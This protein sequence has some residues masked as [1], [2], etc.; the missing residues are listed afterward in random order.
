MNENLRGKC[1]FGSFGVTLNLLLALWGK[2]FFS[3]SRELLENI[4]TANAISKTA[5]R[6][7]NFKSLCRQ[8]F[9]NKILELS[10]VKLVQFLAEID[11]NA[12]R[13]FRRSLI[14]LGKTILIFVSRNFAFR[15]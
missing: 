2:S 13:L 4:E 15:H 3:A 10:V 6:T 12:K 8:G 11:K 7:S 9:K 14:L 5:E 1:S